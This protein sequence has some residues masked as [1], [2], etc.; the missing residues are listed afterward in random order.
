M[1]SGAC[2]YL[3]T[4]RQSEKI[5]VRFVAAKSRVAALSKNAKKGYT[6]PCLQLRGNLILCRSTVKSALELEININAVFSSD[7]L[8]W[9][10]WIKSWTK[11]LK[12][13]AQT[14]VKEIR[15]DS[16]MSRWNYVKTKENPADIS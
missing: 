3:E 14:C 9:L 6:I 7:L 10:G 15:H 13:F 2:L 11:E 12:K 8:G 5:D 16:D 4:T 1:V